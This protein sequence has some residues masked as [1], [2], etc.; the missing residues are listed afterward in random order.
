MDWKWD[1]TIKLEQLR[2][3]AAEGMRDHERGRF[4]TLTD[5]KALEEL[6]RKLQAETV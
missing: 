3:D 1:D 2:R 5:D 4:V 6:F